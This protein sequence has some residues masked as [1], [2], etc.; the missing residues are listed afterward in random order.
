MTSSPGPTAPSDPRLAPKPAHPKVAAAHAAVLKAL[1][2]HDRQD[3]EDASRGFIDTYPDA[4]IKAP[5]GRTVWSMA[6][7]E[8]LRA[9][10]APATVH[11]SLWRQSQLNLNH[12]LYEVVPSLYQVRGID[13]ANM[14]IVEGKTGI[15]VIDTLTSIES[16]RAA[17]GLYFKHRGQRPVKAVVLTHT[18]TDHWGGLRGV[19]DEADVKS[20]KIPIIA[21][22]LFMEQIGRASCRERV[23]LAV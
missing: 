15:V 17:L 5:N 4:T 22:D 2:F 23:C 14:T 1:P 18:H 10:T 8:F 11:P 19:V 21:P 6:P 16:A 13:I 3:F 12:G 20:G 9:E 7:Y